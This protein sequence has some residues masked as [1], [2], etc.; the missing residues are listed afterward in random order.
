MHEL[1]STSFSTPICYA[2]LNTGPKTF[3]I[4]STL[5]LKMMV[6]LVYMISVGNLKLEIENK[7]NGMGE[8][9]QNENYLQPSKYSSLAIW[10]IILLQT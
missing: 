4:F 10:K 8:C 1:I 5:C 3:E 6:L 7:S 2:M 9:R